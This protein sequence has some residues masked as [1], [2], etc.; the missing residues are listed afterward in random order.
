ML[1]QNSEVFDSHPLDGPDA[2]LELVAT[3]VPEVTL[4]PETTSSSQTSSSLVL[5]DTTRDTPSPSP[6]YREL[7]A[8]V[9]DSNEVRVIHFWR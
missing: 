6:L 1:L 9:G 8:M 4:T 2:M 7:D 3:L 5:E